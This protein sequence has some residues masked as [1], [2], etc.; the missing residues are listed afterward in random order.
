MEISINASLMTSL[1]SDPL[2]YSGNCDVSPF[3]QVGLWKD[4]RARW[5]DFHD[6]STLSTP[7]R[8]RTH[9]PPPRIVTNYGHS[10]LGSGTPRCYL[11][12][13]PSPFQAGWCLWAVHHAGGTSPW[14]CCALRFLCD[15]LAFPGVGASAAHSTSSSTEVIQV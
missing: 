14:P 7:K 10:W 12:A 3:P 9:T 4:L 8:T 15:M 11:T 2:T 5:L 13:A 6:F 1:L